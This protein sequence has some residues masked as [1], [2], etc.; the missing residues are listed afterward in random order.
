[1]LHY[2]VEHVG[3]LVTEKELLEA[4][5]PRTYVEPQAVK[6]QVFEIRRV[7]GDDAKTPRYIEPL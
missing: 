2:L 4:V 6:R 5:W 1:M 3:R 7:L